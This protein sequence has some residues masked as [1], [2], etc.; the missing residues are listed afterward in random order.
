MRP[1]ASSV[2]GQETS[3]K[4]SVACHP[5]K[6]VA[7]PSFP[8]MLMG[9]PSMEMMPP[10]TT[11]TAGRY[12]AY[13]LALPVIRPPQLS[14]PMPPPPRRPRS[15][16]AIFQLLERPRLEEVLIAQGTIEDA[17]ADIPLLLTD[18]WNRL[19]VMEKEVYRQMARSE[20][21]RHQAELKT[22]KAWRQQFMLGSQQV[23]VP[24]ALSAV[25]NETLL[26]G[27]AASTTILPAKKAP[28]E[29]ESYLGEKWP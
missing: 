8:V 5:V 10:P 26:R 3:A 6:N 16:S 23:I 17:Y 1:P 20:L 25:S 14:S 4:P 21:R 18:E 29:Y 11:R 22:W 15:A 24:R 19:P 28:D 13:P 12:P 2:T 9:S 27:G 7:T